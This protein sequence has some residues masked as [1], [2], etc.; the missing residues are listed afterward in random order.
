M[1]LQTICHIWR[2]PRAVPSRRAV[3]ALLP[4]HEEYLRELP[5]CLEVTQQ[6][7]VLQ[8]RN[9]FEI[10]IDISN[11]LDGPFNADTLSLDVLAETSGIESAQVECEP[12]KIVLFC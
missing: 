2:I 10:E 4:I 1:I 7:F 12:F 11:K 8:P 6:V 9:V 5:Q 3:L